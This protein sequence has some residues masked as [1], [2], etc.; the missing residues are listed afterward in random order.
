MFQKK[1]LEKDKKNQTKQVHYGR[2]AAQMQHFKAGKE[3][4]EG[5]RGPPVFEGEPFH[6]GACS[7]RRADGNSRSPGL[8]SIRKQSGGFHVIQINN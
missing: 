2:V 3:K 6:R 1:G 4:A 8:G 7:V 5:G